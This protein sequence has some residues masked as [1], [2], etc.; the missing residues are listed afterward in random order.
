MATSVEIADAVVTEINAGSYSM[1]VSAVRRIMPEH[2]LKD[3]FSLKV[4]V[5]P[6]AIERTLLSRVACQEDV[7]IDVAV[8]KKVSA[9]VDTDVP[10]LITL[11]EE[12]IDHL[13]K[14]KLTDA[15]GASWTGTQN[16]PIYAQEHLASDL[17][18]TSII[19]LTYRQ[20]HS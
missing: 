16:D 6:K 19:T 2:E 7:Q 4:T 17:L 9:D 13:T 3:Y 20:A 5:A 11:T 8:Q 1:A 18:F 12:I 15:P 10:S 14:R